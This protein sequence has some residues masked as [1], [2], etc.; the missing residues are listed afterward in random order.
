MNTAPGSQSLDSVNRSTLYWNYRARVVSKAS[1]APD[2]ETLKPIFVAEMGRFCLINRFHGSKFCSTMRSNGTNGGD[3]TGT[4]RLMKVTLWLGMGAGIAYYALVWDDHT[5]GGTP[6]GLDMHDARTYAATIDGPL[7]VRINVEKIAQFSFPETIVVAGR[8]WQ[9]HAIPIYTFQV[10]YPD[11]SSVIIDTAVDEALANT[12]PVNAWFD[13]E[14]YGRMQSVISKASKIVLTHE[15]MDHIGGLTAHPELETVLDRT[16]LSAAQLSNPKRMVPARF[17][18]GALDT[19]VPISYA[20]YFSLA[21][22]VALIKAPGHSPGSQMVLVTLEGGEEFLFVGDIAWH[23]DN[24]DEIKTRPRLISWLFL[25]EDRASV[26][27]QLKALNELQVAEPAL[28]LVV[29]HDGDEIE[30][31]LN[32]SQM[33]RRLE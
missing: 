4:K 16:E 30:T 19:Y 26:A 17:R 1:F 15:H 9:P 29:A 7:P 21:P 32:E 8:N 24:I 22:G 5:L 11:G 14:A 18:A 13:G 2:F 25:K 3:M 12:M 6:Y 20:D 28:N 10:V 27:H 23:M 31:Y 33:G